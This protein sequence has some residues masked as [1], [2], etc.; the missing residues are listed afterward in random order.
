MLEN[1]DAF[2]S[3]WR[4]EF[5]TMVAFFVGGLISGIVVESNQS[6]FNDT[7]TG[8]TIFFIATI[9]GLITFALMSVG[10]VTLYTVN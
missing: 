5:F 8:V 10:I 6:K 4:L 2:W 9:V 3:L 1:T 7:D